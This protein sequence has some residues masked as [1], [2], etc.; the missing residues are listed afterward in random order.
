MMETVVISLLFIVAVV[1]IG[2]A[3]VYCLKA[4]RLANT[5][6]PK[7]DELRW[8]LVKACNARDQARVEHDKA[9][10]Y[11][12]RHGEVASELVE[13]N[14]SLLEHVGELEESRDQALRDIALDKVIKDDLIKQRNASQ[15]SVDSLS[16][17]LKK[18]KMREDTLL[19]R[20]KKMQELQQKL[21]NGLQTI[22]MDLKLREDG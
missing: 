7:N 13:K 16:A 18:V 15:R 21:G 11:E 22:Y 6:G 10:S 20:V 12:A 1:G 3:L 4:W 19:R 9:L 17:E 14:E 5:L 2:M 8:E